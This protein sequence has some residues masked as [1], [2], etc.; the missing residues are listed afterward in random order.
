MFRFAH[1]EAFFL[2]ILLYP[3][4]KF[5]HKPTSI[6]SFPL[7]QEHQAFAIQ[8]W[9]GPLFYLHLI[10]IAAFILLVIALARPQKGKTFSEI[11][12]NG[13]DIMLVLDTSESMKAHDFRLDDKPVDRLVV[14]KKVMK[15]FVKKRPND[16]FGLIVFGDDAFTQCPL[17]LDHGIIIDYID[18]TSIGMVGG[19]TAIGPGI[20]T[21]VAR[22]KDMPSKSRIMIL[23]T[24]GTN[25]S[26]TIDPLTA[27]ELAQT[28]HIKIYTIGIGSKGKVPFL[29][30]TPFGPQYMYAE[31]PIDEDTLKNIASKTQGHYYR[32]T[33]PEELEQIYDDINKLEKT[34]FKMK[35]YTNYKEHFLPWA[36][37]ALLLLI[38]ER[39]FTLFIWKPFP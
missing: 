10:K 11:H 34:D 25:T 14:V 32:A 8:S 29:V 38:G 13:V 9:K 1:P 15:D 26:G 12:S 37:L 35:Q 18:R 20:G 39:L 2:L 7:R 5:F 27:A 24:D 16:R 6:L 4:W 22:L 33:N 31:A 17:T 28:F 30:D 21:A 36:M 19:S 3:L 23:L